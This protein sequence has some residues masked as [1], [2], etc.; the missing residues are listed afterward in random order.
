MPDGWERANGLA[1]NDATGIN[2][3]D[4]DPDGDGLTNVQENGFGTNPNLADTD[5]DGI[6]DG[7]EMLQG[8][9]PIDADDSPIADWFVL[10]GDNPDGVP[11]SATR[12]FIIKKGDSRIVVVGTTSEEYP[13]YTEYESEFDDTLQWQ[14]DPSS[15]TDITGN[16][17]VNERHID[18]QADEINGVTLNGYSPVHIETVRVIQAPVDADITVTITLTATN[19]SDGLLPSTVIIGVLPVRIEPDDNMI[20]VIG[21]KIASNKGEG[22]ERHFVT[23][24]KSTEVAQQYARFKATHLE[25]AWI[26]PQD[27]NQLV[28]WIPGIGD[29]NGDVMRWKVS[30]E[31][32]GKF[33]IR[34]RT[35]SKFGNENA[36]KMN[37]WVVWTDVSVTPYENVAFQIDDTQSSY[38]GNIFGGH[39][40]FL[41]TISHS[42][43]TSST[44]DRPILEGDRQT[45]VPGANESYFIDPS[46]KGDSAR[47]KWDLSRQVEN[48]IFNPNLIPKAKF[49]DIPLYANQPKQ[50]DVVAAYPENPAEGNN[51]PIDAID[52]DGN[53]YSASTTS[54]LVHAIGQLSSSD[55][56]I[57]SL[58]NSTGVTGSAFPNVANFREF[59]R[60]EISASGASDGATTWFRI[61]DYKL[62]HHVFGAIYGSLDGGLT[63]FWKNSD[64]TFGEGLY[65]VPENEE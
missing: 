55:A 63:Y 58:P 42:A 2:G 19:V 57:F 40:R 15:G 29:S 6:T 43:I 24:K 36:S 39:W 49:P 32:A 47:L 33:P 51:D 46:K 12:K 23:P 31:T 14:V 60:L 26:T 30:R 1:P 9:D 54:G 62:W 45:A 27:P 50:K 17:H 61:S 20:G 4:G 37:L 52:E 25:A 59:A 18:W 28:E 34:I 56:P 3:A 13:D 10:V 22:G 64:S 48:Q 8:T 16:I 44:E 5:G 65:T 53:P 35:L 38:Y 41:F 21:D 7:S 11:K